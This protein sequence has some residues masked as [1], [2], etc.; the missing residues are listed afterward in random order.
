M[1]K[2]HGYRR[3]M[4]DTISVWARTWGV[5]TNTVMAARLHSPGIV[6]SQGEI[7]FCLDGI[8]KDGS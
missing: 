6:E 2:I 3:E 4:A 7:G 8:A 5:W 1:S